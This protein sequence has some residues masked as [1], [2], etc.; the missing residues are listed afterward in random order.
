M[1][2]SITPLAVPL[3]EA[4]AILGV[5]RSGIYRAA[6]AGHIKLLKLGRRTLV[7]MASAQRFLER[8]PTLPAKHAA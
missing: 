5:S 4:P 1:T 6:S 2:T 3:R 8:L 7:D